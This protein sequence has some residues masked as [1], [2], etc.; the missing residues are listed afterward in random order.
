MHVLITH[1]D[2]GN[3]LSVAMPAPD[4]GDRFAVEPQAGEV[5]SE[6]DLPSMDEERFDELG[7]IV[8]DSRV[9]VASGRPRLVRKGEN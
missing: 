8:R 1:D 3:I 4:A 9:D 7:E 2:D 5:V 6:L